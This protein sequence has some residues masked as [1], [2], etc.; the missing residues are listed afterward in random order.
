MIH[1]QQNIEMD[2]AEAFRV[3]S[4]RSGI[5]IF[6]QKDIS[7]DQSGGI[8]RKDDKNPMIQS[9]ANHTTQ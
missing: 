9:Q 1:M 4:T 2:L 6:Q 3:R 5:P 8:Q 7:S